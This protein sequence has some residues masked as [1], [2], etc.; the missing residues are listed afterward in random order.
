M[1]FYRKPVHSL[2][3]V[4][5]LPFVPR[6]WSVTVVRRFSR[7]P[8]KR[9]R[10]PFKKKNPPTLRT[11]DV[12]RTGPFSALEEVHVAAAHG[13]AEHVPVREPH[14]GPGEPEHD[15]RDEHQAEFLQ[16]AVGGPDGRYRVGHVGQAEQA[17]STEKK[18]C[19]RK[20]FYE[21]NMNSAVYVLCK[22]R[23]RNRDARANYRTDRLFRLD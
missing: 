19:T 5:S 13:R 8:P 20:R 12:I 17:G 21:G 4:G 23:N 9:V 6:P 1:R 11:K 16:Q 18:H 15:E 14:G 2:W 7:R 22:T 3:P 10:Q